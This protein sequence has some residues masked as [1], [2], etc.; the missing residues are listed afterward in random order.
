MPDP[1]IPTLPGELKKAGYRTGIIGKLHVSPETSFPFDFKETNYQVARDVEKVAKLASEFLEANKRSPFFLM[2]NFSDPHSPYIRD[3]NGH[4]KVKVDADRVTPFPFTARNDERS[5]QTTANYYCCVN[6]FDEGLGLL[7][8]ILERNR[9]TDDTFVVVIGDHGPPF[10]RAK[11]TCYEAGL[12]I[13]WLVHWPGMVAAAQVQDAFVS[14]VDLMPT[15]LDAAGLE[16]PPELVGQSLMPVLTGKR[17]QV[18]DYVF[19]EFT[20]HVPVHYLPQRTVRDDRYKLCVQLLLEP[21]S[22]ERLNKVGIDPREEFQ[23]SFS[24]IPAIGLYDLKVDPHEF[25]NLADDPEHRAVLEKLKQVLHNWRQTTQDPLLN[26]DELIALT[27][28]HV[29]VKER[30]QADR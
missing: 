17:Q 27:R 9:Q 5:R 6:R 30:Y 14:T 28:N 15:F 3:V 1:S 22:L 26:I 12:Q 10:P 19:G 20:S 21:A 29:G 2:V 13:P 23:S 18:R 7:M 11:V 8:D 25:N 24:S 4:P 16:V